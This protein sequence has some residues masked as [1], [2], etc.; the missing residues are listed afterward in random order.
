MVDTVRGVIRVRKWPKKYGKPRSAKQQY[1]VDWFTQANLLAKYADGA[2]QR[3]AIEVSAKTGRYPRD[4][5]L[6]LMRGRLF[7]WADQ[8]GWKWHSMA[9]ITDISNSLDILAQSVGSVLVRAVDRWRAPPAGNPGDVLTYNGGALP[10]TWS[11]A[12]G[13]GG[14][15]QA[16]LPATP[17]VPDGTQSQYD[18]DVTN[19]AELVISFLTVAFSGSSYPL[20]RLSIDGGLTY[21]NGATDYQW[22]Y[23]YHAAS[24][25]GS[26][27]AFI[28]GYIANASG[29]ESEV[30][31]TSLRT[32]HASYVGL[33]G[34]AG[35]G[36]RAVAGAIRF[37]GPVTHIR[38][39][40]SAGHNFTGGEIRIVGTL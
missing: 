4:V 6:A 35:T 37:T 26:T 21:K 27:S 29:H 25:A 33:A 9:A 2:S 39:E 12:A 17:I 34:R 22:I 14:I 15:G 10:P 1:W 13:G 11:P 24:G 28:A 3:Y 20:I 7:W 36:A 16:D 18:I 8:D 30:K 40:S 32:S 31:L 38:V 23:S 19:Y 5:L